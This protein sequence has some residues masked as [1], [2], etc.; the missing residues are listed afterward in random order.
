MQYIFLCFF[1]HGAILAC[2]T[3]VRLK[4]FTLVVKLHRV[5]FRYQLVRDIKGDALQDDLLCGTSTIT[6][7]T[8]VI[9]MHQLNGAAQLNI[10]PF[11]L[12]RLLG[13][14]KRMEGVTQ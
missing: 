11:T 1:Y 12:P 2:R 4:T 5:T 8:E 14:D 13:E 6:A 10:L 7:C 9:K 3:E